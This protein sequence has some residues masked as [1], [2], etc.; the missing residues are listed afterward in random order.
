[1]GKILYRGYFFDNEGIRMWPFSR[2]I[3]EWKKVVKVDTVRVDDKGYKGYKTLITY[4]NN[5]DIENSINISFHE[6]RLPFCRHIPKKRFIK[7]C[8]IHKMV[9][10]Y[11]KD[12]ELGLYSENL[13]KCI[14]LE[15]SDGIDSDSTLEYKLEYLTFL[16][17]TFRFNEAVVVS[18][19]IL[20]DDSANYT[21]LLILGVITVAEYNDNEKGLSIFK[22]LNELYPD[23]LMPLEMIK[24]LQS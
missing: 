4:L 13:A 20:E 7:F 2:L 3:C 6:S 1:M 14:K 19:K 11:T 17:L 21:S 15:F 18:K 23:D 24:N 5:R 16:W 22:K 12:I 9:K 10:Q 8:G